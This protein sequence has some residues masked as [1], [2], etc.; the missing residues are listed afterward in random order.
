M[1]RP[2]IRQ[3][4][5]CLCLWWA[6]SASV[7]AAAADPF[8]AA[9]K[10]YVVYVNGEPLWERKPDMPLPQASLTKIMTALVALE[11]LK[12]SDVVTVSREA[13]LETGSKLGLRAGE[14]WYAGDLL[15]G[16]LIGS[17]NDACRA[18]AD[19]VGGSQKGFVRLMNR[20][21]G[22]LG[23]RHTKYTN[24]CGHDDRG[25]YS[26]ANDLAALS[27]AA[28]RNAT[29]SKMVGI[30]EGDIMSIDETRRIRLSNKNALIGRYA[31][32]T[33]VKTGF[34]EGAG[35]CLVALAEREGVKVL[36]VMLDSP[37]RWWKA[38]EIMDRAFAEKKAGRN[39]LQQR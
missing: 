9:A 30:S 15:A 28:L 14:K 34:T 21:A 39:D 16:A 36:L 19:H 3:A 5:L 12:L 1:G 23:L 31:G 4:L 25:H 35:K 7:A 26:T 27:M 18:L 24:A 17:A 22:Q 29:F 6:A 13:E 8:P 10:S 20:R 38:E 37:D 2:P 32:A 11:H 33:G